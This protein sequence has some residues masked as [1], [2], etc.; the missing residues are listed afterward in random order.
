MTETPNQDLFQLYQHGMQLVQ[1]GE[2]EQAFDVAQ[3]L[4]E[5]RFTGCFEVEY[6]AHL[7]LGHE[8]DALA[9]LERGAQLVP[10]AWYLW[11]LVGIH[12]SDRERW[13][14]ARDALG[15]A[16]ACPSV[17]P[18][19]I[20]CNLAVVESRAGCAEAAREHLAQVSEPNARA[21]AKTIELDLLV[22]E[23]RYGDAVRE[24]R[25]W[26]EEN[27][28][29]DRSMQAEVRAKIA[30]ALWRGEKNAQLAE[31]EL[32]KAVLLDNSNARLARIRREIR[33]KRS[34]DAKMWRMVVRGVVRGMDE[35]AKLGFYTNY[36]VVAE[37]EDQALRFIEPF[38]PAEYH[39]ELKI[40]EAEVVQPAGDA[41]LGVYE[42]RGGYAAFPLE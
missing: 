33:G 15:Q 11:K 22:A 42:K 39:S 10:D 40:T 17:D 1:K 19:D 13:Q 18:S 6:Q 3:A 9:A 25:A 34:A 20:H 37:N 4:E 24:A 26:L 36:F 41:L 30:D 23:E 2:V 32:A 16:L 29:G 12:H 5:R 14:E 8:A 31:A 28:E 27:E 38:E 21:F 7:A 35:G